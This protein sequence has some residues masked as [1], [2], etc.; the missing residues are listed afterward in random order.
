MPIQRR[1]L[2][3]LLGTSALL[4]CTLAAHAESIAVSIQVEGKGT[5]IRPPPNVFAIGTG[6]GKLDPFGTFDWIEYNYLTIEPAATTGTLTGTFQM[7]FSG[8]NSLSGDLSELFTYPD[9]SGNVSYQQQLFITDG[10]GRFESF[11]GY[12]AGEGRSNQVTQEFSF[13]DEGTLATPEPSAFYFVLLEVSAIAVRLWRHRWRE[14][15][16]M[17]KR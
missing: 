7:S 3:F 17:T 15:P 5:T 4:L 12:L 11:S 8:G 10:S 9:S 16:Q 1:L 14:R 2:L 13:R 6:T